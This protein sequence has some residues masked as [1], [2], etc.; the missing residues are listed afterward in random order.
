MK[1][2]ILFLW[3]FCGLN[4]VIAQNNLVLQ[5]NKITSEE[6][7][8]NFEVY[9]DEKNQLT[10]SNLPLEKFIP[11]EKST[12]QNT[13][14]TYWLKIH[15]ENQT[16]IEEWSLE[17]G[18][19]IDNLTIYVKNGSQYTQIKGGS[20]MPKSEK[21]MPIASFEVVKL[22]LAPHETSDIFIQIKNESKLAF[23]FTWQ[24]QELVAFERTYYPKILVETSFHFFLQGMYWIIL[25]YN[26]FVFFV[27]K[28]RIYLYYALY[29]LGISSFI[30]HNVGIVNE[31]ITPENAFSAYYF[32]MLGVFGGGIFYL[33]FAQKFLKTEE[34]FPLWHRIFHYVII[35]SAILGVLMLFIVTFFNQISL[36][37]KITSVF[38]G[39][40]N[41]LLVVFSIYLFFKKAENKINWYFSMGMLAVS[42]SVLGGLLVRFFIPTVNLVFFVEAGLVIEILIFSL[43]LGYRMKLIEK[44]KIEA[45]A[46]NA[47]ILKEQNEILEQRVHRRTLEIQQQKEE[48]L[49][50]NEELYQQ[51]E[52]ILAQRD[53][54]E[55]QN[56]ELSIHNKQTEDS[57]RAALTIQN[58]ILPNHD[59]L[60]RF[61]GNHFILYLPKDIVSG[62]FF[63]GI[64]VEE[65]TIFALADCTGH[66]VSGAMMTMIGYSLLDKVV[67]TVSN[68]LPAEILTELNQE[69]TLITQSNENNN[70]FGMDIAIIVLENLPNGENLLFRVQNDLFL[71][72]VSKKKKC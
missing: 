11:F 15:I 29:I 66:G 57:I 59:Q 23:A 25:I 8:R 41:I 31:F 6:L 56:F 32:R 5:K 52:E 17:I 39:L 42:A 38:S 45:E 63:W 28:D 54:I 69:L 60:V 37:I 72:F 20:M 21:S 68:L 27:N 34:F 26:L 18:K 67:R 1:V 19:N 30:M 64:K 33:I 4:V 9:E 51:K 53:Y 7:V 47:R 71:F 16:D 40:S 3:L 62:D 58:A 55:K 12:F 48:I 43:G 70:S 2:F 46:E 14:S 35:S 65:K 36:Y 13:A 49:V 44:Q 24:L 22:K 10:I 61:L 50:Q